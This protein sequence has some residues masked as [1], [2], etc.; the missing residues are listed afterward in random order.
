MYKTPDI[1]KGPG[2]YSKRSTPA[3][4]N[5]NGQ[6]IIRVCSK[7]NPQKLQFLPQQIDLQR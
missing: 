2:E 3:C 4:L 5:E 7:V 1:R 6:A